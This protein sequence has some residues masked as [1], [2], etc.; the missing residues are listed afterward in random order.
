MTQ[1]AAPAMSARRLRVA[2][3]IATVDRAE[4]LLRLVAALDSQTLPPSQVAICAPDLDALPDELRAREFVFVGGVRGASA[5]RNAAV[6]ALDEADLVA[7]FDDDAVPRDDYLE[8]AAR[9]FVEN[10]GVVGL[11]GRVVVDGAAEHRAV[12]EVEMRRAL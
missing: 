4:S 7:F 12:P 3:A 5:Q 8:Q 2:V 1:P 10:S 6:A 9:V 11:T